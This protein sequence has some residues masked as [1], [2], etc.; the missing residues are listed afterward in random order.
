MRSAFS[1][2]WYYRFIA[3]LALLAASAAHAGN[4]FPPENASHSSNCPN[5]NMV[6]A[7]Q[8]GSVYCVD[9]SAVINIACPTG[10]TLSSMSGGKPTCITPCPA[11][12]IASGT[13]ANGTPICVGLACPSGQILNGINNGQPVCVPALPTCSSGS[14]LVSNGSGWACK[15]ACVP[16]NQVTSYGG[17]SASCGGG[18]QTVNWS[19]GCGSNWTT[20][21]ACNTNAC[22]PPPPPPPAACTFY[23]QGAY[24]DGTYDYHGTFVYASSAAAYWGPSYASYL[25]TSS[26]GSGQF[27]NIVGDPYADA[28][29]PY[30]L[31]TW[32]CNNGS[33]SK[34]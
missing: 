27:I 14:T 28:S 2:N 30:D 10:Q 18:S 4:L 22:A 13:N 19:D 31:G 16:S 33:W 9:P 5:T 11:G 24:A 12:Q 26:L 1:R 15:G 21:Q 34:I 25:S 23:T 20:T 3:I 17:C 32:M 7:W 29:L 6:L 8:S